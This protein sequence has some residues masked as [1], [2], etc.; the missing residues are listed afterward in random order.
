[1]PERRLRLGTKSCSE[2]R[3]RKIRCVFTGG[4]RVCQACSL[5]GTPCIPQTPRPQ[6]SRDR[7][8]P[9]TDAALLQQ[10]VRELE[11]VVD[12]IV[13][14]VNPIQGTGSASSGAGVGERFP[15]HE[16]HDQADNGQNLH[17]YV[18]PLPPHNAVNISTLS[19]ISANLTSDAPLA[20]LLREALLLH[21]GDGELF[22]EKQ[23]AG[24][25]R[26]TND[27]VGAL[28]PAV[29]DTDTVSLILH[30][31]KRFWPLWPPYH[32]GPGHSDTLHPGAMAYAE[33][34]IAQALS[35]GHGPM[36]CKALL[37][38][39]LCI[40]Q[41][42]VRSKYTVIPGSSVSFLID[43][44]LRF[45]NIL[46]SI[47]EESG[48]DSIDCFLMQYKILINMGRPQRAWLAL[49]RALA[50]SNIAGFH[51]P[52]SDNDSMRQSY[53][54]QLWQ[55][56]K[57]MSLILG[58][59]S[60]VTTVA[61]KT[62][63][64]RDY[65]EPLHRRI[66]WRVGV[67]C[68]NILKRNQDAAN[69]SYATTVTLDQEAED[70]R[71]LLPDEWWHPHKPGSNVE[72]VYNQETTKFL[73]FLM[74]KLIHMPYMLKSL[75]NRRYDHSCLSTMEAS[76][77]MIWAYLRL[78]DS[79]DARTVQ[80]ELMDFQAFGAGISLIIGSSLE[81]RNSLPTQD[82]DRKM[83]RDLAAA[84]RRTSVLLDCT[85]ADQGAR[86]LET[87]LKAYMRGNNEP[88]RLSM[89][90]PYFGELQISKSMASGSTAPRVN[91]AADVVAVDDDEDTWKW[92]NT[93]EFRG[94]EFMCTPM[95]GFNYE[96]DLVQ[97]WENIVATNAL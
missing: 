22:D 6:P 82:S 75:S 52:A 38:L 65:S 39:A 25:V 87:L 78:R 95:E 61:P 10:R 21:D 77:E 47:Q 50:L 7:D 57:F 27:S 97:E 51:R 54:S 79:P 14:F 89:K 26:P 9:S 35:T 66:L 20:K 30:E 3:R 15:E 28:A 2:C 96:M 33:Q 93:F 83:A 17:A 58:L 41:L 88:Y 64:S 91:A 73:Y 32:Y 48:L 86:S 81:S 44:Y 68:D 59:P 31:T 71:R 62:V 37:W 53:W 16:P 56:D 29:P 18:M 13:Q 76:R 49:R 12:R 42:P 23:D 63:E 92:L 5:H 94:N 46:L 60:G 74:V 11:G 1:M 34:H 90:I 80:C 40:Q 43:S 67:I 8:S 85:V 36:F 69:T 72:A 55:L 24:L 4:S 19:N 70:L 84:L 45:S